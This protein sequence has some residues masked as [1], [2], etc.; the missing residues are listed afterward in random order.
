MKIFQIV[1]D[2]C[3]WETTFTDIEEIRGKYPKDCLFVEAPDYVFEGWRFCNK[4]ENGNLIDDYKFLRPIPPEGYI[5]NPYTGTCVPDSEFAHILEKAQIDKQEENKKI[6]ADFLKN[7]PLLY[8]DGKYYGVTLEDQTE[9]SLNINQYHLQISSGIENPILE[10]HS[11]HEGCK[12]WSIEDLTA[13][14]AT[15][16]NYIYPLFHKMQDYKTQIFAASSIDEVNSIELIYK[17]EE[18]IK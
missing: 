8:N 10:W 13:L 6:F 17:M 4:D 9:I 18:E 16:S 3:K 1:N 2:I 11:I 7:H 14:A 15:I 5:Y 12:P